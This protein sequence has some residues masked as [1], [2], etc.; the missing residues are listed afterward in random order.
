MILVL[1]CNTVVELYT[2]AITVIFG[3]K[4]LTAP[5]LKPNNNNAQASFE[6]LGRGSFEGGKAA[7]RCGKRAA[8][9]CTF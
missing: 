6:P 3:L 8:V 4:G 7:A 2:A 9:D 5:N 1:L